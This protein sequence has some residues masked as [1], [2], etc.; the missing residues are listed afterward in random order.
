MF[1]QSWD[2]PP[3]FTSMHRSGIASVEGDVVWLR[4]TTLDEVER[5]HRETLKL[6]VDEANKTYEELRRQQDARRQAE[7]ERDRLHKQAVQD[8][9]KRISFD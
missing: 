5:Y 3:R 8:A 6:A 7:A 4:G 1:V 2:H 9:A